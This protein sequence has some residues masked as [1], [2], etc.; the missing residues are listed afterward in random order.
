VGRHIHFALD[1][2]HGNLVADGRKRPHE[3]CLSVNV[4]QARDA[5]LEN[6]PKRG[7][8][9]CLSRHDRDRRV[10]LVSDGD[11]GHGSVRYQNA[12]CDDEGGLQL[13]Q[14]KHG[15]QLLRSAGSLL[16]VASDYGP[17]HLAHH[18]TGHL[19]R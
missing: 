9:K 15:Q 6:L 18:V 2:G 12:L 10:C 7:V 17:Q 3:V 14:N 1:V 11:Q 16:V 4:E 13:G 19:R 8:V 5:R